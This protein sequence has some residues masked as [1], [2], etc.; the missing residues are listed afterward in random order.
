MS[1]QKEPYQHR[2]RD[3]RVISHKTLLRHRFRYGVAD[4]GRAQLN[5]RV[6]WLGAALVG[7]PREAGGGGH[8]TALGSGGM[9]WSTSRYH[10]CLVL[11]GARALQRWEGVM[12]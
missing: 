5:G 4:G 11:P 2:F 3:K 1:T 8:E 6:S 12:E 10:P 9:Q 7:V